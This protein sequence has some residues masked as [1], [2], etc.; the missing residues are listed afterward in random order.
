[1]GSRSPTP[2]GNFDWGSDGPLQSI[3]TVCRELC[4]NGRTDRVVVCDV[5]PEA[6]IRW[7]AHW[8]HLANTTEP[9]MCGGDAACRQ[10]T[11]TTCYI[12]TQRRQ[13]TPEKRSPSHGKGQISLRYLVADRSAAGRRPAASLEFGLSSSSANQHDLAGLRQV[14][15]Q[16][17]TAVCDQMA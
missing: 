2:R 14:R 10:V 13:C 7:C 4:K 9:S 11:S 12:V 8:R 16:L 17:R 5:D 15:D 1:M 3:G 6:C